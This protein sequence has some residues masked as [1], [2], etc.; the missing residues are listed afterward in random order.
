M[1]AKVD[2]VAAVRADGR[3]LYVV[4]ISL[5]DAMGNLAPL[6]ND[7]LRFSLRGPGRIVGVGNGDPPSHDRIHLSRAFVARLL[8]AGWPRCGESRPLRGFRGDFR[9]AGGF[10]EAAVDLLLNTIGKTQSAWLN[11]VEIYRDAG[12]MRPA[13][14]CA[15]RREC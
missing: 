11:G 7:L 2:H 6:A 8:A 15:S 5:C 13:P 14:R 1:T 3:D 12:P 4:D 9:R 10:P